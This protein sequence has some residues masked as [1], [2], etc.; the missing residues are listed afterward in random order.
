M[1]NHHATVAPM[2][3]NINS[4]IY[5]WNG[6]SFVEFQSIPTNGAVAW[7][8]FSIGSDHYLVVA[9]HTNGS[10][11]S[12]NSRVYRWNGTS[13]V[14]F[15][16][17]P[18]VGANDWEFFTIGSDLFLAVANNGY[19]TYSVNS[20]VYRWNGTSFAE[21]QSIPTN[22]A[23]DWKFFTTGSDAYLAVANN[24]NGPRFQ[25]D[26]RI[27]KWSGAS[28]VEFQS[29]PTVGATDWEFFTIGSES[30]LAVANRVDDSGNL[31]TS[32]KVFRWN[33]SNF[34]EFQSIPTSGAWDWEFFTMDGDFY[35]VVANHLDGSS[36]NTVS[37]IYRWARVRQ[38]YV[39]RG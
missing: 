24:R 1:A 23:F 16:S 19:P 26:S 34:T 25:I 28:F 39:N 6:T 12:V 31:S 29:I 18:T 38:S 2:T 15:Q 11:T 35:L 10:T 30:Y 4:T 36:Y 3:A 33:G 20:N 13:F 27:Y 14:E 22:G 5:R 9:N 17:I 7:E 21:F 37:R 32:S 8:F